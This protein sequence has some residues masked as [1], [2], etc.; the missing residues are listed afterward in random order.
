MDDKAKIRQ[1]IAV[2]C[3]LYAAVASFWMIVFDTFEP[4]MYAALIVPAWGYV[5]AMFKERHDEK[6]QN[7]EGKEV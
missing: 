3:F 5:G 2:G 7:G 1:A 4:T 6:K